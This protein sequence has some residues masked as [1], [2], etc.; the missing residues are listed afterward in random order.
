MKRILFPTD[1]SEAAT[2]AFGHALAFA[3]KIQGELILYILTVLPIDD[4][5]FPRISR[6]CMTR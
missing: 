1:F 6:W 3:K 2:N 5:F 4:Q